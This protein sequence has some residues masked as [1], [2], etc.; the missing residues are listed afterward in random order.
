MHD[1][2][3]LRAFGH[4][5]GVVGGGRVVDDGV[6]RFLLDPIADEDAADFLSV[7]V[8]DLVLPGMYAAHASHA[9]RVTPGHVGIAAEQR[10]ER[11]LFALG[12]AAGGHTHD[13]N[14]HA[15]ADRF[16]ASGQDLVRGAQRESRLQK[17]IADFLLAG[18]DDA[19]LSR[20]ID[21]DAGGVADLRCQAGDERCVEFRSDHVGGT[22]DDVVLS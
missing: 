21:V 3:D 7:F 18:V 20:K 17:G 6:L 14:V 19:A 5:A 11:Y 1:V 15:V 8:G 22:E 13:L 2:D 10:A 9:P 16:V 12:E 4:F